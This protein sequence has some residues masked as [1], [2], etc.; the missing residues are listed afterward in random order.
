[1]GAAKKGQTFSGECQDVA[2]NG[3]VS[4]GEQNGSRGEKMGSVGT[5]DTAN[6]P[7]TAP[8]EDPQTGELF[9]KQ[10][11]A[12]GGQKGAQGESAGARDRIGLP[13]AAPLAL[14]G[15]NPKLTPAI[16]EQLCE[17]L[18]L[19]LSRAQAAAHLGFDRSTIAHAASKDPELRAAL[20]RAEDLSELRPQL[21]II[22]ESRKN[23]RAALS[24]L[25]YKQKHRPARKKSVEEKEEEQQERLESARRLNEEMD[26]LSRRSP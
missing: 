11:T 18:S 21:T 1:M 2:I 20:E 8:I 9:T 13:P 15:R 10:G 12:S 14:R 3:G 23:W 19:G 6:S 5:P 26:V 24:W 22:A 4:A 25:E 16:L 17:L 7:E